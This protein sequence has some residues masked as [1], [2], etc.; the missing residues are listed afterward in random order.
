MLDA[1]PLQKI[2]ELKNLVSKDNVCTLLDLRPAYHQLL[3]LEDND[4]LRV[5]KLWDSC[6]N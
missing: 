6:I 5:L 2:E 3:M 4:T 1:F